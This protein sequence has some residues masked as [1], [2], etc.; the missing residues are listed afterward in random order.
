MAKRSVRDEVDF[1]RKLFKKGDD[2]R[3]KGLEREIEQVERFDDIAYGPVDTWHLLDIYLPKKRGKKVP[4]I[5]HIH[6]GGWVYGTKETYQFFGLE[7]AKQ[8][9]AFVNFNYR[10]APD[11]VFPA[12]L[13]DVNRAFHWISQNAD[14]YNLDSENIF[15]MGDSAGGQ[16]TLQYVT[17]LTNPTFAEKFGYKKP[18]LTIR[19][20]AAHC[21]A[22]FVNIQKEMTGAPLTYFTD[23]VY[24]E[25]SELLKTEEYMTRD[26]PPLFL[27]TANQDFIRDSSLRLNGYLMAKNIFHDFHSYGSLDKPKGHVFNYD[28]RDD[29]AKV[30]NQ[31][32][33]NFFKNYLKA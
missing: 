11:V 5:I 14:K 12:Q 4:T 7:M 1:V 30:C 9:F 29:I 17:A 31:D 23:A 27:S 33:L 15:V 26:F 32:C 18:N 16:M 3:D 24:A 13:D 28:I 22:T 25:K 21:P 8:G 19:A 10:L 2:K 20:V 6:G